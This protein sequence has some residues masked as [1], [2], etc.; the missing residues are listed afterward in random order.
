MYRR[1]AAGCAGLLWLLSCAAAASV[2]PQ[3]AAQLAGRLTPLGGERAGN[4]EGSIPAWDGGLT[5]QRRPAEWQAGGRYVDPYPGDKPLLVIDKNNLASYAGRLSPGQQALF[6]RFPDSYRLVVY[7]SRRS[8]AAPDA[9]Y[10]GT[11]R[12]ATQAYLDDSTDT[13]GV[14]QKAGLGVPFPIP[15]NGVEAMWNQRL[16]WRGPGRE[17]I[18]V[19]TSVSPDGAVSLVRFGERA[20]FDPIDAPPR[21]KVGPV[22]AYIATAVFEPA[23][24]AG[25]VKLVWDSL[26]PPSRAWQRSPGQMFVGATSE[27]GGDTPSLGGN[28]LLHE[29][30]A[31]G[32]SGS[33]DR[34]DWKLVG[35]RE[36]YVPY[37]SYR[38][39]DAALG[40]SALLGPHHLNPDVARYELHRVW[41]LQG[42]CRPAQPCVWPRRTLYLD[43]DSWAVLLAEL[44]TPDGTLAVV[45]E[46][47]SLMA[48]D[49]PA[50]LP[51]LET[52]YDL[53]GGRYLATGMNNQA[54]EVSWGA[55]TL[56]DFESGELK[57][58]AKSIGAVPQKD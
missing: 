8:Y 54:P 39:H 31:E 26:T 7:P 1:S 15:A 48:Y 5:P 35:K 36:L 38:L 42:R 27:V 22:L 51:A 29:D 18:Y 37:N 47:H 4:A 6:A 53:P 50:L 41:V 45:Q 9:F 23:K 12:N 11:Y 16:R 13:P 14:P 30:Q 21:R 58:W 28:G 20:R 46:E 34:Y 44:Y 17:R 33:T 32:Y 49:Q 24:L 43:E 10:A 25:T 55:G 19:Q 52:V 40:Y 57:R 2:G 3:T 56:D